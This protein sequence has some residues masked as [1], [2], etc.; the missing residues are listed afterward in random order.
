[1]SGLP[2]DRGWAFVVVVGFF[3]SSFI[4]VGIAKSYGIIM[5]EL[6]RQF[7]IP[8]AT[9]A[10]VMGI[11]GA[12]YTI[13][14]PFCVAFGEHFTQR[15][16]VILGS[17]VGFIMIAVASLLV[18]IEFFIFFYGVGTGLANACF[19]GNG[20][21]M[22]GTYFKRW[23]SLAT[24]IAL[25]G[26]SVGTFV[27][28]IL[29]EAL[30]E[31]Y[32]LSGTILIVSAIYL[33]GCICGALY[34]PLSFYAKKSSSDQEQ[35]PIVT[36][37]PD[38]IGLNDSGTEKIQTEKAKMADEQDVDEEVK[39]SLL[40]EGQ[41]EENKTEQVS[42]PQSPPAKPVWTFHICGRTLTFPVIFH[43]SVLALP[44]VVFFTVFSFLVF[45]G[46]FNFVLFLPT[47][48]LERGIT[49]YEK[50][51]LV[52]YSGAG[53]LLGR[54]LVGVIGD[55][56]IIKRYKILA[57]CS[58]LCG[59]NILLFEIAGQIYWWMSIH[60]SLY[61]FFGGCYVAINV[62]VLIDLVGLELMPK[63]LG[64][65]LLIQGLGAA[66]GQPIEGKIRDETK[67]FTA[68]NIINS[69][70]MMAA[71]LLLFMYPLVK[72]FQNKSLRQAENREVQIPEEAS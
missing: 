37:E 44:V 14:A 72:R 9:G 25:T 61:G 45:I 15:K 16:M 58:I 40:E 54:I 10:L 2:I 5:A 11:S 4:M 13:L 30:L 47:D 23:R 17:V 59:V 6:I 36:R 50:A 32:S 49:R 26:A 28:P 27:L 43:F 29:L 60:A 55:L 53:D 1:M 18:N 63:A 24:G 64:V 70:L 52:S 39:K 56:T 41:M 21:V 42:E 31:I 48:A 46:Y 33:N 57:T 62:I 8:T 69:V 66:I 20:L 35:L 12:V 65:V 68:L 67:S 38:P 71:G 34:R 51:A 22:V 19:F 7:R 3:T